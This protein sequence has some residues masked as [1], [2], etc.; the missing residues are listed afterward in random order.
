MKQQNRQIANV[1]SKAC[2][3]DVERLA[4]Q[5]FDAEVRAGKGRFHPDLIA[6]TTEF[7]NSRGGKQQLIVP[8][9]GDACVHYRSFL[10][11]LSLLM[12]IEGLLAMSESFDDTVDRSDFIDAAIDAESYVA[13]LLDGLDH[14]LRA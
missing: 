10:V 2:L 4:R 13:R 12:S 6:L 8:Q 3:L 5:C 14:G 9:P 11:R 7:I 1:A